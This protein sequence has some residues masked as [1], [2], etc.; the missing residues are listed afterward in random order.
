MLRP[1]VSLRGLLIIIFIHVNINTY[2][3]T[4]IYIHTL[5]LYILTYIYTYLLTYKHSY[6]HTYLLT[7]L[8]IYMHTYIYTYIH[9]YIHLTCIFAFIVILALWA[10]PTLASMKRFVGCRFLYPVLFIRNVEVTL[11]ADVSDTTI[12]KCALLAH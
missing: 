5:H 12:R 9:T 11:H 2:I 8:L 3:H 10:V 7:Y 6:I 1:Y 4:Y